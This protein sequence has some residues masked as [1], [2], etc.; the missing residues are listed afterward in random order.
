MLSIHAPREGSDPPQICTA[1][2]SADFNPR[3]TYGERWSNINLLIHQVNFNPR[4]PTGSDLPSAGRSVVGLGISIHAPLTGSDGIPS[5]L[6]KSARISIHA[7]HTG[8]DSLLGYPGARLP[9]FQSTLPSRGAMKGVGCGLNGVQ[10]Q[11]TLHIRGAMPP[12]M[13]RRSFRFISI[14]APR[15]EGSDL[16]LAFRAS[17][18]CDFN[19]RSPYGER[20]PG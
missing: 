18:I 13:R 4:P 20:C 17:S 15:S 14:H 7:P 16:V 3:S 1:R 9:Q 10:L 19:P 5:F 2:S 6:L 12:M 11:S 8:S